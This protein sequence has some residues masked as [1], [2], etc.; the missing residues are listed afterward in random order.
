[1]KKLLTLLILI[2]LITLLFGPKFNLVAGADCL[3]SGAVCQN[4]D[5]SSVGKDCC[6]GLTCTD[7]DSQG[8]F[9]RCEEEVTTPPAAKLGSCADYGGTCVKT[10]LCISPIKEAYGSCLSG[11]SCCKGSLSVGGGG[12]EEGSGVHGDCGEGY[13]DT[14]IGCIPFSN[15]NEFMGFVLK[16]AIG[17]GGGIAF[18]L[19]LVA[20]FQ[21][22]TSSGNPERLKAGQELLTS[23]LAGLILIIFSVFILRIIGVDILGIL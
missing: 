11:L 13:I 23:A 19:I 6:S 7:V 12:G 9:V 22:I 3:K 18:I 17:V 2:S 8:G 14:A 16:W 5:G 21:I 1:M 15:T 4:A 20:G 10:S